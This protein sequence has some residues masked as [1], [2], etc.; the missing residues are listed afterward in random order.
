MNVVDG[1]QRVRV[2]RNLHKK[3]LSIR[4]KGKVVG[5]TDWVKLADVKFIVNEAGR[6]RCLREGKK[7]VHAFVEGHI[8]E[9]EYPGSI[10][11]VTYNPYKTGTFVNALTGEPVL[12]A[13]CVEILNNGTM[14]AYNARGGV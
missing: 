2:A 13:D 12:S 4:V 10:V 7:N 8:V 6:Q 11:C 5:Y 1:Q 14:V 3:Q 9:G